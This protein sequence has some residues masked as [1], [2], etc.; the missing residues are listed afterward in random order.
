MGR[1]RPSDRHYVLQRSSYCKYLRVSHIG[2]G[3]RFPWIQYWVLEEREDGEYKPEDPSPPSLFRLQRT[4]H[5]ALLSSPEE[6]KWKEAFSS[7]LPQAPVHT[8]L[9]GLQGLVAA[10]SIANSSGAQERDGWRGACA[11]GSGSQTGTGLV[12]P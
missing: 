12:E 7:T 4:S 11:E 3:P 10:A 1:A 8:G 6:S 2:P 5:I 9:S